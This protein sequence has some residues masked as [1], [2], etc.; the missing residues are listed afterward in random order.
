MT[1]FFNKIILVLDVLVRIY[2]YKL[3]K[4]IVF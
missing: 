3:L 2:Q 4:L 1:K